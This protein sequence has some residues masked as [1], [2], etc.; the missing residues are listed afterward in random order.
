M[1]SC[2]SLLL[3]TIILNDTYTYM[4]LALCQQKYNIQALGSYHLSG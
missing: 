3:S 1:Y 2:Q 4:A